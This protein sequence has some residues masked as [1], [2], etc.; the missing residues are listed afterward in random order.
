MGELDAESPLAR[1]FLI[2]S[3]TLLNKVAARKEK[4]KRQRRQPESVEKKSI[5]S[6]A[7]F[8]GG[9]DLNISE[10]LTKELIMAP[11]E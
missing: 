10:C 9:G 1:S 6:S 3:G 2:T 7:G 8:F 11:S 5:F 4:K